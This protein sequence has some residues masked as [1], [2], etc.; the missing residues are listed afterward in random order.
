MS[1]TGEYRAKLNA[2]NQVTM[3]GSLREAF[4]ALEE[5]SP[6]VMYHR[7]SDND[8]FLALYPTSQWRVN[9]KKTEEIAK[10]LK[11]PELNRV[12]NAGAMNVSLDSG[13]NGRILI[14][15]PFIEYFK[16]HNE[17]IFVG[18]TVQIELWNVDKYAPVKALAEESLSAHTEDIFDY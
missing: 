8:D 17:I 5:D 12:L 14:P 9:Q 6:L 10:R 13:G 7:K 18:N 4:F 3:P 15:S 11:K 1:F 16:P 2:K